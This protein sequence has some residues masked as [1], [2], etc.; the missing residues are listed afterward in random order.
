MQIISKTI[1]YIIYEKF[2]IYIFKINIGKNIYSLYSI[3]C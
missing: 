3:K 2:I 1:K